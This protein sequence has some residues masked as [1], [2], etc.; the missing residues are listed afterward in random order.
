MPILSPF[1]RQEETILSQ[2]P[3]LAV[4]AASTIKL[5]LLL[6]MCLVTCLAL[7][8]DFSIVGYSEDDLNSHDRLIDLFESWMSKHSKVYKSF[9]EKLRRFEVFKDNL[10]HIDETNKKRSSYWLGLNEFADLSHEEFKATYLGLRTDLPEKRDASSNFRYEDS[11]DLPTSVD[12]R[13][14]GAVTRV[15]NQGQCGTGSSQNNH[16]L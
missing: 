16:F 3:D 9:E 8:R 2:S 10:K 1:L 11:K 12:W 15:K 6:S 7:P 14:K 13:K 5:S 4:M